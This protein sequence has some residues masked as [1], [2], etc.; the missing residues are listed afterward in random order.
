[1]SRKRK[2]ISKKPSADRDRKTIKQKIIPARDPRPSSAKISAPRLWAF[3]IIAA[4]IIPV[5]FLV[6]IEGSLRIIGFGNPST[7]VVKTRIK[8][9]TFFR[10]NTRYGW[11]FF[12]W[13]IARELEPFTF[14]TEKKPHTYRIFILG[15]SAAQGVPDPDF[16]FSR[17]LQ[18]MLED[19]YPGVNFEIINTA[20]VAINSHVVYKTAKN[21]VRHN[22]DLFIVYLGNNEVVGPFGAGTVFNPLLD[23]IEL[24]RAQIAF[25]STRLGQL[26]TSLAER[27][28]GQ[29]NAPSVWTGME[30]FLDKQVRADEPVLGTVYKHYK[31][32]LEDICQTALNS[33]VDVILSTV[34]SNLRGNP[35]FASLHNPDM[36]ESEKSKWDVIYNEGVKLEE[37]N[38]YK[39]A[40]E[41]YLA[42][43]QIDNDY[44]DLQ[45]RLAR[46]YNHTEQFEESK[47]RYIT[48]RNL[49]TLR[50][51]A[52]T[53]IN[54]IVRTVANEDK[55]KGKGVYLAET[56]EALQSK[57]PH[58][59]TG[60]EFFHEHVHLN[61]SGNY[62]VAR[63]ILDQIEQVLPAGIKNR[64][65]EG[66]GVLPEQAC[67]DMLMFTIWTEKKTA[68][69]VLNSYIK[70]PPFTNQIYHDEK[71][72]NLSTKIQTLEP[73][74]TEDKLNEIAAQYK[75]A[76]RKRDDWRVRWRY[77][78]LLADHLNNNEA[79][80][81]HYRQV[82]DSLPHYSQ[83]WAKL[84]MALG[85]QGDLE[86]AV[87]FNTKA[88][89][90]DPSNVY[91]HFNLGFAYNM[92]QDFDKALEHYA[93]AIHFQPEFA[94]AY[95]N[96][97]AIL[98][99]QGKPDEAIEVYKKGQERVP[100]N[101]DLHY[102]LGFI[103][104]K[105][106]LIDEAINEYRKAIKID[107]KATKYRNSLNAALKI[108]SQ[109]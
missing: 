87:E 2:I 82:R 56:S 109:K 20:M 12:P 60:D 26:F 7:P 54:E 76:L 27:V 89:M 33:N 49:D 102:N 37:N 106:G 3:R 61:F 65:A 104:N 38:E 79:A 18:V 36:N 55:F 53:I 40:I 6:L 29:K 67:K 51:R 62:V 41:K 14:P 98:F 39:K 46:C 11:M 66:K 96:S 17:I 28:S 64:K 1:M 32:N 73:Q 83:A 23:K 10:D 15:A 31:R 63:E 34:G 5:V 77:A 100:D 105:N 91:Y 81:F 97:G 86:S 107:P 108:K 35:P 24:I 94:D 16:A 50:F 78:E 45:F 75:S 21:L 99:Q 92:K 43:E 88:I 9:E 90:L 101:A 13:Q 47:A 71:V 19:R 69:H 44:A 84:G 95:I 74:L 70:K 93:V 8:G 68:L 52:D 48:A 58:A 57:S 103:Y 72:K 85:K 42:A 30:M 25:K 4:T 80:S 59:I 22:G